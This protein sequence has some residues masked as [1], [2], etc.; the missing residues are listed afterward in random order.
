M[1]TSTEEAERAPT[2]APDGGDGPGALDHTPG[3]GSPVAP[4]GPMTRQRVLALAMPII[5]EN[6]LQTSV[7]AVDTLM[8]SRLGKEAIAGVGTAVEF[9]FFIISILIAL[10]IGATVLVSQSFGAGNHHLANRLARQAILW[11]V[12]L[13]IPLSILGVLVAGHAIRLFG[14]A[15]EVAANATT[16]LQITSGTSIALLLTFVCGAVFR[17]VGDSR[18]PLTASIVANAVNLVAAY[19]LIFGHL[20]FPKLGVAGSAWGAAIGRATAAMIL[21]ALLVRGRRA[22][23]IRGRAGWLPR[24]AVGRDLLRLGFP[25]A[26]EQMLMSAGFT[27][28]LA[29]VAILGTASLAAQQIGFTALSIAFMPGFGFALAATALVGQSVGAKN[30]RDAATAT[31]IAEIWSIGWM[32]AGGAIYFL[33]ASRVM[34]VFTDDRNVIDIGTSALR[35]LSIGLPFWAV[36]AVNGG[37]LRGLGDTRT[38]LLT[39]VVTV[40]LAVGLAYAGVAWL[41][42]G[43]GVVWLAF[44]PTSALGAF[45]NWYLLRRRLRNAAI[46]ETLRTDAATP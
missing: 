11:G 14:T 10:E 2:W 41:D 13:A 31:R 44:F 26:L 7:G 39:S 37:A 23:S 46:L 30:L 21:L 25:A 16:Y 5:G 27:T 36:W 4:A 3:D 8:V 28:M 15:P 29:V 1:A 17:G 35:A 6:L 43:L 20:G 42:G 22:V 24:L 32:A 33:L 40:W 12:L 45:A 34:D 9:V 18:T 19:L 38:P